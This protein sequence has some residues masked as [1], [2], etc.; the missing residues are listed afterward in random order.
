MAAPEMPVRL[1]LMLDSRSPAGAHSHSGGMESAV[2]AGWIETSEDVEDFCRGR[3]ATT[4]RISAAFAAMAC[5]CW[6][7]SSSSSPSPFASAEPD[8]E[9]DREADLATLAARW[10][11]LDAELSARIA[12]E[13]ARA[14]S[15]LLGSGLRRLLL[16]TAPEHS[17]AVKQ[18]WSKIAPAAP[19]H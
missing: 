1:L 7:G 8:P 18:R 16:A 5:R 19:H 4:A 14:A 17:L 11:E 9:T 12:S 3:L 10:A 2:A 6:L 13:A 15:R